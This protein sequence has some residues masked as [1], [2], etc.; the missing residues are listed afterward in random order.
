MAAGTFY[1]RG[2]QSTAWNDGRNW[3]NGAGA[4]YATG[5]YPGSSAGDHDTVYYD[6][7][8]STG[9]FS[10]AGYDA[11]AL[12]DLTILAVGPDYNGTIGS[13]TTPLTIPTATPIVR[14]V[15]RAST[16]IYLR[17]AAGATHIYMHDAILLHIRGAWGAL[18][19][20]RGTCIAYTGTV[21]ANL[22][23]SY[24]S[25]QISDVKLTIETGCTLPSSPARCQVI[26]GTVSCDSTL[27]IL[28]ISGGQWTQSGATTSLDIVGQA[29]FVWDSG[30]ITAAYV[31][32]GTLDG[33]RSSATRTC[34]TAL[35]FPPATLNTNNGLGNCVVTSLTNYGGTV[36][37]TPGA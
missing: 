19:L 23:S 5:R 33:S 20:F 35:V 1:W 32:A 4:Y 27:P 26:G 18:H 16:A 3:V 9:A 36:V 28:Y 37:K 31:W 10:T 8:L 17:A 6:A 13:A 24:T 12:V 14:V 25:S 29:T 15:G 22:F 11:S 21:I 2:T 30:D 34:T 7:A